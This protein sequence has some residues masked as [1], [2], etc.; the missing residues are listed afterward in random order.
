MSSQAQ[1]RQN[2]HMA[3]LITPTELRDMFGTFRL[4]AWRLE[5][6]TYN[7]GYEAP[8]LQRFLAGDPVPPPDVSWWRPWLD[9]VRSFTEQGRQ[10]GRVRVDDVPLSAYQRWQHWAEPWHKDA[11][12]DIRHIPR[13]RAAAIGLPSYDY[14]LFDDDRLVLMLYDA[15]GDIVGRVLIER[16]DAPNIVA[17][18][19]AW[20]D[21]AISSATLAQAVAAS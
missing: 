14:W 8:E 15:A 20:R 16:E 1:A 18:H 17:Q 13:P 19:C 7:L 11:G 21:R 2:E 3:A 9:R 6:G 5:T 12:E 10:V 4:S